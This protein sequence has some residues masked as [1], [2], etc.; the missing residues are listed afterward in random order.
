MRIEYG[1]EVVDKNGNLLGTVTTVV[2]N[3]W[4]GEI[5]KFMIRRKP[6]EKDLFVSP[7]C[8]LEAT[9]SEIKLSVSSYELSEDK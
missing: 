4:T 8:V 2:R 6:P 7:K 3:S 9:D 1:A 5:S